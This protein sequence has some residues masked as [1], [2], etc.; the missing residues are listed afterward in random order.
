MIAGI[1]KQERYWTN[2]IYRLSFYLSLTIFFFFILLKIFQ[3]FLRVILFS[4]VLS[5]VGLPMRNFFQKKGFS[6]TLNG[7]IVS[8]IIFVVIVF[9]VSIFTI[10]LVHDSKIFIADVDE[11]QLDEIVKPDISKDVLE[12]IQESLR[13]KLPHE[14]FDVVPW[15][16]FKPQI[17]Q[18][19]KS[20]ISFVLEL[21]SNLPNT[22]ANFLICA[23][24]VFFLLRDGHKLIEWLKKSVP[25][26][27]NA[28]DQ[29]KDILYEATLSA[30]IGSF[31]AALT[32]SFLVYLAFISLSIPA[33]TLAT[34]ATF[35]LAWIPFL[36]AAPVWILGLIYLAF[37]GYWVK[38]LILCLLGVIISIS[39]NIVRMLTKYG[40]FDLHPMLILIS[41][42]GGISAFGFVGVIA[43]PAMISV[44]FKFLEI[45][46]KETQLSK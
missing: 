7:I 28:F 44:S 16:K 2:R 25:M 21:T 27:T 14:I 9:P 42:L 10:Q 37:A 33:S 17:R 45:L 36:G 12:V 8:L 19:F 4:S 29:M 30:S 43:G 1:E 35:F 24:M 38:F 32:Q 3:P 13:P 31:W 34:A 15:N 22:L 6:P 18:S 5:L 20:I 46:S 40:H 23:L 39:D 26:Q 11:S 41:T